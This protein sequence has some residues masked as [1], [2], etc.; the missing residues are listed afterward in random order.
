MI[1]RRR[2]AR[3]S[4]PIRAAAVA[5]VAAR[6]ARV[7]VARP[8]VA[9][10]LDAGP[11]ITVVVP[12]RDEAARIGPLLAA[13][14][15]APDVAAVIVVDDGSTDATAEL[16]A[17]A[18]AVVL[19]GSAPPPGWLGKPW[20]LAQGVDAAATEWVVAFDADVIPDPELPRAVVHRA[21]ADGLDLLTV[22]GTAD[23][24]DGAARWL[25]A[26]MLGQLV[27]R[28]G[29]PGGTR[30]LANGQCLAARRDVLRSG[31]DQVAGELVEDVALARWVTST[32]GRVDFLD[33]TG[34]MLVRPY[35]SIGDVWSGWGRS[36]GLRGV[37]RGWR[38]FAGLAIL[39]PVLLGAPVRLL[40]GR[41][42]AVAVVAL[43][44]RVG[45]LVGMRRSY[46]DRG[47]AYWASP[48]AD[49]VALAATISGQL[50]R[51]PT[52]RG[53]QVG[54]RAASPRI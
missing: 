24:P 7:M 6:L 16:A 53:R 14:R 32:G 40:R 3:W 45:T 50:R 31:L 21:R 54:R 19:T 12:A 36:I 41:T 4:T 10:A 48:L 51:A 34:L 47:L 35:T 25:H 8:P 49:P 37:D 15:G 44:L 43:A 38:R 11:P 30:R 46:L 1:V 17:R 22:A 23:L 42:D 18:G 26:A 20:A 39:T 13:L 2:W 52:W 28:F 29:P 5:V 33:A 27:L 9:R